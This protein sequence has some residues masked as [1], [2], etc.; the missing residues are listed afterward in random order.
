MSPKVSRSPEIGADPSIRMITKTALTIVFC[1][2]IA[3][4]FS[5]EADGLNWL[6][7]EQ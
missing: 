7:G 1:D 6:K 5:S 3:N 4:L 2:H